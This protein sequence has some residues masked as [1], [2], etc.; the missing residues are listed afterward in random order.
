MGL[1]SSREMQKTSAVGALDDSVLLC[2]L[3]G[4]EETSTDF[5]KTELE[6]GVSFSRSRSP[7]P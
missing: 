2:R 5:S 4:T 6:E 1:A 7:L 3:I